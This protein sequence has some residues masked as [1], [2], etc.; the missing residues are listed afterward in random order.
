L[1]G[2]AMPSG[3]KHTAITK[4]VFGVAADRFAPAKYTLAPR[5]TIPAATKVARV[6]RSASRKLFHFRQN[7]M[8]RCARLF[9]TRRFPCL[10]LALHMADPL[11]H[12][13][14]TAR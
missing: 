4:A 13:G 11:I 5:G 14:E 12:L 8:G 7:A 2:N 3:K 9:T 6:T 1:V 10:F